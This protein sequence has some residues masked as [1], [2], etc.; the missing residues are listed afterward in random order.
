MNK[1]ERNCSPS[2]AEMLSLI[3][4]THVFRCYLKG[5]I[6]LFGAFHA[7]LRLLKQFS[8][9]QGYEYKVGLGEAMEATNT[10]EISRNVIFGTYVLTPGR[11]NISSLSYVT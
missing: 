5:G 6:F 2:E 3:W 4:A 11:K 1:P 10:Y 9:R 8:M 7:A